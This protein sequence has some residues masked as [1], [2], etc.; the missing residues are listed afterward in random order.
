MGCEMYCSR[1]VLRWTVLVVVVL[2]I[3]ACLAGCAEDEASPPEVRRSE[4]RPSPADP[5]AV[6]PDIKVVTDY[7]SLYVPQAHPANKLSGIVPMLIGV[8]TAALE[9]TRFPE[10]MNVYEFKPVATTKRQV[11]LMFERIGMGSQV[12]YVP[13]HEG[14]PRKDSYVAV[15]GS[16]RFD[17][18]PYSGHFEYRNEGARSPVESGSGHWSLYHE[19]LVKVPLP[20]N[21][22]C[23]RATRDFLDRLHMRSS[24]EMKADS[25]AGMGFE[26]EGEEVMVSTEKQVIARPRDSIYLEVGMSGYAPASGPKE[27]SITTEIP[28]SGRVCSAYGSMTTTR[29]Y[30]RYRLKDL[31]TATLEL[32]EGKGFVSVQGAPDETITEV[33]LDLYPTAVAGNHYVDV[34]IYRFAGPTAVAYIGALVGGPE[35]ELY[36]PD[37][38]PPHT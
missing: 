15:R 14:N 7:R 24:M 38:T 31:A 6:N 10:E 17:Y 35:F 23:F 25:Y 37:P 30:G 26:Y 21:E 34:P 29:V 13:S 5:G 11:E 33:S 8:D 19:Y 3:L 18:S 28:R 20:T 12:S 36:F 1:H 27:A 16:E 2:V 4:A 9:N 22:R 32:H